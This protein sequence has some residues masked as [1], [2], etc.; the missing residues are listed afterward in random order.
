AAGSE[1]ALSSLAE[2]RQPARLGPAGIAG[3]QASLSTT[4]RTV[5]NSL[6]LAQASVVDGADPVVASS[7]PPPV[8]TT[9]AD[10][11]SAAGSSRG[12]RVRTGTTPILP[13][14][15]PEGTRRQPL[16][17]WL[18]GHEDGDGDVAEAGD[19]GEGCRARGEGGRAGRL[20]PRSGARAAEDRHA[21]HDEQD[22]RGDKPAVGEREP[23]PHE[24]EPDDADE[25]RGPA[26]DRH[27]AAQQPDRPG[28][29][30]AQL[31]R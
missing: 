28:R 8:P 9:S 13:A 17:P 19:A 5:T 30:A 1:A 24:P 31:P 23:V 27:G 11:S 4:G 26:V 15:E 25:Q 14:G 29:A 2:L 7:T 6:P 20:R 10:A 18:P 22:D 12:R 3:F 16:V 21:G